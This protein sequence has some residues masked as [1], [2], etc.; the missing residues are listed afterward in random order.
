MENKEINEIFYYNF[1]NRIP[2]LEIWKNNFHDYIFLDLKKIGISLT[3]YDIQY[4][5]KYIFEKLP[6]IKSFK[7]YKDFKLCRNGIKLIKY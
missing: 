3:Y 6:F 5:L 7:G 4:I 2:I 1:E